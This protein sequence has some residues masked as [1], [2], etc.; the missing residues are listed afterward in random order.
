MLTCREVPEELTNPHLSFPQRL[1]LQAHLLICTR[2]RAL[3]AQFAALH[4]GLQ[5]YV[6]KSEPLDPAL[7]EKISRG[8]LGE[9]D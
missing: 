3:Q 1:Q 7:A 2:C 9:T 6:N 4:E 5:R 8:Y